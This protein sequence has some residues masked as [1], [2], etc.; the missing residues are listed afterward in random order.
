M[1]FDSQEEWS[2]LTDL[3][4]VEVLDKAD[5]YSGDTALV[6]GLDWV[7]KIVSL[8]LPVLLGTIP[9]AL[10]ITSSA[11]EP[12]EPIRINIPE[13]L[14]EHTAIEVSV[15]ELVGDQG[16]LHPQGG[17]AG[18][19]GDQSSSG[20]GNEL[21]KAS[22]T[23]QEIL[24]SQYETYHAPAEDSLR[25]SNRAYDDTLLRRNSADVV[26][27]VASDSSDIYKALA[28]TGNLTVVGTYLRICILDIF[29]DPT[30]LKKVAEV[31]I[32]SEGKMPSHRGQMRISIS[33]PERSATIWVDEEEAK[34]KNNYWFAKPDPKPKSVDEY[35]DVLLFVTRRLCE[36][37]NDENCL[38]HLGEKGR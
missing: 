28:R 22:K 1:T 9:A 20:Q 32:M 35:I 38:N 30:R 2:P 14:P 18:G 16:D 29:R 25:S 23:D 27:E 10:L 26:Q 34:D 37:L 3:A 5:Y 12:R 4:V 33:T 24:D 36:M 7:A 15:A 8:M 19:A 13:Y 6:S 31:S 21:P 11:Q 17:G